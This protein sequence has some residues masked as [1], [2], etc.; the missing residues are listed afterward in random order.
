M[1]TTMSTRWSVTA[2][3]AAFIF[4]STS[5]IVAAGNKS[6]F[7]RN[8]RARVDGTAHGIATPAFPLKTDAAE[9]FA[10]L[11]RLVPVG[12][13]QPRANEVPEHTELSPIELELRRLDVEIVRK[14]IICRGC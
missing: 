7:S 6:M 4:G 9:Q 14:L 11:S 1:I 13:R 12:H 10:D 5:T 8:A 2:V 3:V